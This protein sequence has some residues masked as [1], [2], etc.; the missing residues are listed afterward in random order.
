[1]SGIA[2]T[3]SPSV[4]LTRAAV[5][6]AGVAGLTCAILLAEGGVE[7][8]LFDARTELREIGSGITLQANALR[9]LRAAGVWPAVRDAGFGFE[10]TRIRLP[11]PSARIVAELSDGRFD[12][13]L[14]ATLGMARP[15]LARILLER[16]EEVGVRVHLGAAVVALE[17]GE[18]LVLDTGARHG[19][20]DLV[21]GADGVHSA[22]RRLLGIDEEP[23]TMPLGVW[24]VFTRRPQEVDRGEVVNGG[25][26]YFSGISPVSEN[27]VYA[28]L[29]EDAADRRDMTAEERI[30]VV[31]D[32]ASGY[33]G[34]WD[35]VRASLTSATPVHYTR[36]T[37]L[38]V[39][40][41]WHR[42]RAVLI[43]D[44][45]HSC[46]PTMAQGAAQSLED[47]AVL[48]ELLL[49]DR[50]VGDAVLTEYAERRLPR[51]RAVV[52]GSVRMAEWQLRHER[53]DHAA[54]M[55]A[56]SRLLAAPA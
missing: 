19:G 11:D 14:P 52:D 1:M 13:D 3:P 45:V 40:P 7:V 26:A 44:A 46:P 15:A 39:P 48:A 31:R 49:R 35:D 34:P 16:A 23:T 28:W 21:V 2:S 30:N 24:R 18:R 43:G 54:L 32:L 22:V 17:Q 47:A 55:S 6:G 50:A 9:V 56:T 42:G 8:D 38:L 27:E 5:A 41:P 20:F 10:S 29:V 51:V 37:T 53:G 25:R 4:P 36:Y 33:H 12:P